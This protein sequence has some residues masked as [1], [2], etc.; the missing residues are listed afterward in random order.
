MRPSYVHKDFAGKCKVFPKSDALLLP[1]QQKWVEDNSLMKLME[2]SRRVG[3]SFSTAYERVRKHSRDDWNLDS[4]ISSRDEPTSRLVIRGC[5]QFARIL[6]VGAED[7]GMQVLDQRGG[8]GIVLRFANHTQINSVAGNPDVFAGK[9][10][11]VLLDEFAL[12][13]D[14]RGVYTVASPTIDWGGTLAIVS[15]HRGSANYF[16]ELVREIREK[17][18][19][20]HFS[21]HRVTLQDALDQGFLYKLQSKLRPPDERLD[22]D[23]AAYFNYQRSRAAD[24]ESFLQEYMCV[25]GDDA[26]AFLTYDMIAS[27]EYKEGEIWETDLADTKNPLFIGVDVGRDRD[28]TS[29]WVTE[30]IGGMHFTRRQIDLSRVAFEEQEFVLYEIL[31]LPQVRRCCIDQT[32]LG[33]QFAERAQ[34]KFGAYKVEGIHFTGAVKEELAYPVRAAFEDKS[35]RIPMSY[36][37]R[38]D[39]RGIK[40]ETTASGNIRFTADRGPHGHS[41]RFWA[42]ALALHA[43]KTAYAHY[44]ATVI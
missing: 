17:K 15:T 11:D 33:R 7:L 5:K 18:N 21:H 32:G 6:H 4:W 39:L 41:D 38:A 40:K 12:R 26:G 9:G 44:S 19:P 24:E 28:L 10:G 43:G 20:K 37:V 8:S 23:E 2:K 25:P 13:E 14:P 31:S 1:Y 27:C 16:N 30:K 35:V 34:T 29:I 3:I 36:L 22:M 42:L